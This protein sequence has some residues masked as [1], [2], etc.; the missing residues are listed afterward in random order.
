MTISLKQFYIK[1]LVLVS[2][3]TALVLIVG[4]AYKIED[5]I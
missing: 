3:R 2:A 4:V 5:E 1:V